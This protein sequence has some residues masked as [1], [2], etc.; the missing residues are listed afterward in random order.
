MLG[1]IKPEEPPER[2]E[3]KTVSKLEVLR[4]SVQR[5]KEIQRQIVPSGMTYGEYTAY[6]KGRRQQLKRKHR[7]YVMAR[8]EKKG[9]IVWEEPTE[10]KQYLCKYIIQTSKERYQTGQRQT[11][12]CTWDRE[13]NG[14]YILC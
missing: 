12:S 10:I 3:K 2:E 8:H 11:N 4:G 5:A 9:Y 7:G 6:L 1:Y 13:Y 14:T